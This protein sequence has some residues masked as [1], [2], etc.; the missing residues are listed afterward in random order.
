MRFEVRDTG[1]G[2]NPENQKKIFNAFSQEDGTVTRKYGGTGLGLTISNKLL[3]LMNSSLQLKSSPGKGSSF[4]FD[5]TLTVEQGTSNKWENI[6]SIKKVLIVDDNENNRVIVTQM[7]LLEGIHSD[8][9]RSGIEA[10]QILETGKKYD[11]ILMDYNMPIM[12]GL[13]TIKKIRQNFYPTAAQQPIM[14]LSSSSDD[15]HGDQSMRR[16]RCESSPGK[17]YQDARPV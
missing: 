8:I 16:T 11:V 4:Y 13:E 3:A 12:D 17:T 2:I 1:I 6:S 14:L 5:L 9:A 10:L 15:D 7:L